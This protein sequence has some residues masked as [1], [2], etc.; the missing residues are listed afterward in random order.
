MALRMMT[1]RVA[2]GGQIG[3]PAI[4]AKHQGVP[5][6]ICDV[7]RYG[8]GTSIGC[9]GNTQRTLDHLLKQG[10]GVHTSRHRGRQATKRS[11]SHTPDDKANDEEV[12]IDRNC[13]SRATNSQGKGV[14]CV[15]GGGVALAE[16]HGAD[17][18]GSPKVHEF[19]KQ[20]NEEVS[21][22]FSKISRKQEAVAIV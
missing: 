8:D 12:A 21:A 2:R 3:I 1:K 14:R 19:Q 5:L 15:G 20:K 9:D 11:R 18:V 16:E 10:G 13:K 7:P 22:N 17:P 4:V 6:A